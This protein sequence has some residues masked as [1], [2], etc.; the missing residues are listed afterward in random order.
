M[1]Q[2]KNIKKEKSENQNKGKTSS[3]Q[4]IKT[5]IGAVL[6]VIL[7]PILIMNVTLIIRS[8][9]D[10]GKVPGIGGRFPLIVMSDSMY[11]VFQTGDMLICKTT[12]PASLKEGDII[13]YYVES[14]DPEKDY[15]VV[16]HRI[17]EVGSEDG[18]LVFITQGDANE[19]EDPSKVSED[20]ILGIYDTHIK[21]L[22]RVAMFMQTTQGLIICVVLPIILL[23][24]IDL[25]RRRR[26]EKA[27]AGD[28]AELMAE[29]EELKALKE[30][31]ERK[32]ND[33][34]M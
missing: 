14:S 25:V 15:S 5:V 32:D 28:T 1:Q 4:K 6:C 12:D 11:P 13:V 29:L 3:R 27:V 33:H 19:T 21:G 8:Y 30:E 22:G 9:I 18:K 17:K 2:E 23:V 20:D 7:I 31:K 26:Y 34:V 10:P 16:A 24:G